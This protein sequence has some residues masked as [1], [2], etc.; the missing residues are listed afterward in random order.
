MDLKLF[1]R[2]LFKIII[3][4][5]VSAPAI[6]FAGWYDYQI[7]GT[8]MNLLGCGPMTPCVFIMSIICI[9]G[10]VSYETNAQK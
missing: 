4:F 6:V 5:S 8:T 2:E 1:L 7:F 9:L 3:F 10:F